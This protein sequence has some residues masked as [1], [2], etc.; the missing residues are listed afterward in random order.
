MEKKRMFELTESYIK[1]QIADTPV[2]YKRGINLYQHGSFVL[3]ET[4][5]ENGSFSYEVDGNY[6][7]YV[8]RVILDTERVRT[9]CDCPYPGVGCKHTVAVLLDIRDRL[10]RHKITESLEPSEEPF[11]TPEEIRKQAI[12][13]R[14]SRARTEKFEITEG[15]MLKGIH[16]VETKLGRQYEVTLHDPEKGE[17]HCTCPDFLTNRLGTCKHLIHLKKHF[18]KKKDFKKQLERELFP[19]VDIFWDSGSDQPRMFSERPETETANLNSVLGDYF[20]ENGLYTRKSLHEMMPLL[21]ALDQ[22]KRIRVQPT[23]LSR[24]D[25][26]LEA[27]QIADLSRNAQVPTCELKTSLYPYQDDGVKFALFKKAALI[28]DEMGLGKTLQAIALAV[29]KK[30]IFGF[31]RVLVVTL[32]SLKD[33]WKREIERFSNETSVVVAGPAD[34]RRGIYR[35]GQYFFAITNYE[36]VLRDVTVISDFK[37]DLVILDEA[38]RIKNFSTKT[39]EAVKRLPRKHAL[40]LTGTPLENKLEDVYSIVQFLDPHLLSPLWQFAADHFMISRKKKG[41]ILGYHNLERLHERLNPLVIRRKKEEVLKD[42]PDEVVNN[43]Y[44]DLHY[45]QRE[46]YSGY[47]RVLHPLLNKKFLTPMDIRRIQELLV[48]M[49][50]VCDSTYLIDRK[51]H[52]SPK[53]TELASVIDELVIESKRKMVIFSEWT[54]MTFL[55]ARHLSEVGIPFVEL[56]GKIPVKKRQSLIDEFTNNPDCRVFLSTDA[57]GTGLNLQAADCVVNFELPWNPAK[58]NQRIGRVSRIGQKSQCINVVNFIC[59]GTV[60]EKIFAGIQLKTELFKGVFEGGEDI[61]EFTQ[62]KKDQM[63]NQLREMMG[64]E[65]EL[66][67][68]EP[69]TPEEIPDDTPHYLNPEVLKDDKPVDF[70]GE[71]E[72][73]LEEEVAEAPAGSSSTISE[74]AEPSP[75]KMESVLNSGMDFIGGLLEAATGQKITPTG[76]D[77]RMVKIDKTTGE[78][79]LKFK[80]P[81]F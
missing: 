17:G 5:T 79:T 18:K 16:L 7:D 14:E 6:G 1:N 19:F 50:M 63:L 77:G 40:V 32:A 33:Q 34:K 59:K 72:N 51:T 42:L 69:A 43:Y 10:E 70:S 62:E 39:A 15:E 25:A 22:N 60:E 55:I 67:S 78:V 20:D 44:V 61:V 80:L 4:D 76:D 28:G 3:S 48:R 26:A 23:V 75:E 35:D 71:E 29:M 56:S 64:E 24:L 68:R 11:L 36:A 13:D 30:E 53:L 46:I 81:G 65:P 27:E 9:S 12:A 57:G 66:P 47:V 45:E 31:E 52:V 21:K 49:R 2:I 73:G 38:Q 58:L 54:T 41:Y 8:T 74:K 37:P